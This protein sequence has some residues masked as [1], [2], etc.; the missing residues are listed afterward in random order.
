MTE[1]RGQALSSALY[2]RSEWNNL[3]DVKHFSLAIPSSLRP[4]Y[5]LNEA[6]PTFLQQKLSQD[7]DYF[8]TESS[9]IIYQMDYVSLH[10]A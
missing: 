4:R 10:L 2:R 9:S 7:M 1:W 8:S 5:I 6:A 3:E